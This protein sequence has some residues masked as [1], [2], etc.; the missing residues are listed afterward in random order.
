MD[1]LE[2]SEILLSEVLN[3]NDTQRI[4]SEY[5]KKVFLKNSQKLLLDKSFTELDIKVC[6]GKRLPLGYNFSDSG[7]PYIRAEDIKSGFVNYYNSPTVSDDVLQVLKKYVI[8]NDNVA[9]TIVGNSIGDV[10]ISKNNNTIC[11]LTENCAKIYA[12][13][14][15][16]AG[17]LYAFLTSKYGQNQIMR[18][19]VGTAQPKLALERIRNFKIRQLSKKI[20]ENIQD[21]IEMSWSALE[22]S[23]QSYFLATEHL[24]NCFNIKTEEKIAIAQKG[25]KE[26]FVSTGRLDAEYYQ[27][28]YD[29]LFNA[30]SKHKTMPLSGK[31]GLV[32]IKKS[33]EPGSEAYQEDGIP[34]IR[35][36]DV[37]KYEISHPHIMISKKLL[38]SID[39]LYPKKDTI[40]LSKDGSIG[41]AYK[42]EKDIEAV[43]S[44]ALLHLTVKDSNVILPD[45]L[46]LVL[47]S[48]IVQLQA[49][50]DCSGAVIQHWKPS[51]I[52]K[53][54]IPI[55]DMHVQQEIASKV[56]KSFRLREESKRLLD[57][58]VQT[59]EMAIETNEEEALLWLETQ[60]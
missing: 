4:D 46:T 9:I 47:N 34:F 53:V 21:I 8:E 27:P 57:L 36:S 20:Q 23:R 24:N 7:T 11:L 35:V 40:L 48:P 26:S 19:K 44:G 1:G 2:V 50:R 52:E 12:T 49:E 56:Q 60:K 30:L 25:F 42:L 38:P 6:G 55:L 31:Q 10:A 59:V 58:A 33:I 22:K 18:E 3:D 54:L 43:T 41:I 37:D 5:F 51:D 32:S 17:Y 28:K 16:L 13:D 45:Y 29:N 15:I 14:K 39:G